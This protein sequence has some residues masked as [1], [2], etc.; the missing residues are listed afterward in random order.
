MVISNKN[1][2]FDLFILT[3]VFYL[4]NLLKKADKSIKI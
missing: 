2:T 1:K 3:T 4:I